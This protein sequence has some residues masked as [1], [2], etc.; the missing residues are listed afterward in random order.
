MSR[1]ITD[2]RR[3]RKIGIKNRWLLSVNVRFFISS[4]VQSVFP[5][6]LLRFTDRNRGKGCRNQYHKT[7]IIL[8]YYGTSRVRYHNARKKYICVL[9]Y[10]VYYVFFYFLFAT[11]ATYTRIRYLY[12]FCFS[13]NY[14]N[15]LVWLTRIKL[16][17]LWFIYICT[18]KTRPRPLPSCLSFGWPRLIACSLTTRVKVKGLQY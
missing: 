1:E 14:L 16:L 9:I 17:W 7:Y 6:F 18:Y 5:D 4:C 15:I 8:R 12:I 3:F 2:L 11:S 10:C 13:A